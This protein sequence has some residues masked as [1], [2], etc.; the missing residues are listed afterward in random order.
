[1]PQE[2]TKQTLI[3]ISNIN[4]ACHIYEFCFIIR[5]Q[6]PGDS[7]EVNAGHVQISSMRDVS[8]STQGRRTETS[9]SKEKI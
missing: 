9:L 5:F 3:L 4:L 7:L 6:T 2:L 8:V 1:M